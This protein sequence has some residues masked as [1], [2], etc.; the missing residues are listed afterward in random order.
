MEAFEAEQLLKKQRD[1]FHSGKTLPVAYRKEAL[2]KLRKAIL[3]YEEELCK[4]LY[5]DLGKSKSESYMTEIGLVLG[6]IS[7]MLKHVKSYARERHIR[8]AMVNAVA[9]SFEKPTPYGNVLIMSPWNYPV[10]LALDPLVDALSAGNTVILKPSAYS[11]AT[12]AVLKKMLSET[13]DDEYV[14]VVTGGRAENASLLNLPVNYIFFTG[15][16][17]VGREVIKCSAKGLVPCTLE[18]GGKSPAIVDET[19]NIPLAAKRIVFGKLLN[20]G[21]TCV[22]VDY[23]YC[24]ERV[25]DRFIEEVI[26]Q[27]K[28]QYGENPL[29]NEN[30]G[31]IINEKHFQRLKGLIDESKLVYGGETE[32]EKC[33]IAPTIMDGITRED[34]IMQEE[35]FGPIMPVL[36]FSDLKE[37]VCE[38]QN[39]PTPLAC[40]IFS[41]DKNNIELVKSHT[42]FGGGCVNDTIVHM[43]LS[44]MGFGG[45]G[46]SGMGTYHGK[47]GFETF[48]HIKSMVDKKTFLDLPIRYQPYSTLKDKIIRMFVR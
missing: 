21:Q 10:L 35:I 8:T 5:A 24:H 16:Q 41:S 39:L 34:A 7:H 44:D 22:A 32:E 17:T 33:R 42:N 4:A 2:L 40:Y 26:K 38:M 18:L 15:S 29:E 28:L 12:T 48:S 43:P 13:F 14:S 37:V 30:Y 23:V 1:F 45:V 6:E 31:K 47:R 11:P 9:R 20:C 25:K 19:A 3:T 27:I 46:E 36:T